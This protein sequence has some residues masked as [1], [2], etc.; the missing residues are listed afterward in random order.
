MKTFTKA[1]LVDRVTELDDIESKA[2]AKRVVELTIDLIKDQV[3]AGNKVDV[4]GLCSFTPAVQDARSGSMNGKAWTSPKKN[5]VKIKP[6]K[7]FRDS[8]N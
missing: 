6:A 8:L 2:A 5:V 3:V 4:S 1:D 7:A